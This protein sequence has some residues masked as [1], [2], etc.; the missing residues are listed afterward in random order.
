MPGQQKTKQLAAMVGF[1][2]GIFLTSG[3]FAEPQIQGGAPTFQDAALK[4][5]ALQ[6]IPVAVSVEEVT[7]E[8]GQTGLDVAVLVDDAEGIAGGDLTLTY[9]SSVMTATDVVGT[10][11]AAGITVVP[12]LDVPGE[13]KVSMAGATGIEAGSGALLTITFDVD[14]EAEPDTYTLG[15][16]ASLS[17]ENG[18]TI[19]S[20]SADGSVTVASGQPPGE[21]PD[22]TELD[23]S[24]LGA[25]LDLDPEADNQFTREISSGPSQEVT[26][27]VFGMNL[28]SAS[29]FGV[30]L[31]FDPNIL[32]YQEAQVGDY[33]PGAIGLP[34]QAGDGT[35]EFGA[36]QFGGSGASGDGFL[37]TVIFQTSDQFVEGGTEITVGTLKLG[38][39]EQD[40][41]PSNAVLKVAANDP[42]VAEF[43]ITPGVIQAGNTKGVVTLDGSGSSDPDGDAITFSWDVPGGTFVK[44]TSET[45]DV[46]SVTLSESTESNVDITLTVTDEPG[47]ATSVTKTLRVD[48]TPGRVCR[49]EA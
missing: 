47:R 24:L 36:A 14:A 31:T 39:T 7:A 18:D 32:T 9:D 20:T 41:Q 46:A 8:P 21:V 37:G 19:S 10:D 45:S 4:F 38:G 34:A 40:I 3:A 16:V 33:L 12:N 27:Q 5:A 44:S 6:T 17:D 42:P 25:W 22:L 35:V 11:L 26:V 29:N 30:V 23:T 13:V 28:T 2:V 43:T 1:F 49:G 48:R 15:L